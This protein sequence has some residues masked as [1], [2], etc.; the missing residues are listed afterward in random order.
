MDESPARARKASASAV[1]RATFSALRLSGRLSVSTA[2]G[3]CRSLTSTSVTTTQRTTLPT[4]SPLAS[5]TVYRR[6]NGK[7]I[8]QLRTSSLLWPPDLLPARLSGWDV[9]VDVG[10]LY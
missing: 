4:L 9:D 8:E 7:D 3:P 5:G 6:S 2:I 10:L 1:S